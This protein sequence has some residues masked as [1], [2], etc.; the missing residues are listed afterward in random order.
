MP[1]PPTTLRELT[2]QFPHPGRIEAI[3]LRPARGAPIIR[4]DHA[5]AIQ[6]IGLAGDRTATAALISCR[7]GFSRASNPAEGGTAFGGRDFGGRDFGGRAFRPDSSPTTK[8]PSKRQITLI[9]SEHL[10]VIAALCRLP[11]GDLDLAAILRRNL[12]ISGLNLIAARSLFADQPLRL[13]ITSNS[14]NSS[15]PVILEIT[16]PCDPCSKMEAPTALGP[17]AYNAMRGHG[18]MTARVLEGGVIHI[19]DVVTCTAT[20]LEAAS[21]SRPNPRAFLDP[22]PE[23]D[24]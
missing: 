15:P 19:G 18:G 14:S 5:E 4:V 23:F 9:Q 3:L 12:V 20:T 13:V 1:Q 21:D 11:T 6:H 16:G 2:R 24:F 7:S 8:P 22:N 10:P 17:G